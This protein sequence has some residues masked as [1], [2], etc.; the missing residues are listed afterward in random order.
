MKFIL[1]TRSYHLFDVEGRRAPLR[2]GLFHSVCDMPS[3]KKARGRKNRA[4]KEAT[5]TADSGYPQI[6]VGANGPTT[7][8]QRKR[9]HRFS[10][11]AHAG[12]P[13]PDPARG[14]NRLSR[15]PPRGRGFLRQ[16]EMFRWRRCN[17]DLS[18]FFVIIFPFTCCCGSFGMFS[19]ATLPLK[20]RFGSTNAVKTRW[21]FAT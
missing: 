2:T 6:A 3:G 5:R 18:Q 1:S 15:E 14:S 11:R 13:S 10:L 17:D 19:S 20:G 21:R 16:G 8:H 4:K 7:Q 9:R 12:G